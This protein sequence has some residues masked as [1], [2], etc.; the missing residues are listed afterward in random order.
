MTKIEFF[1]KEEDRALKAAADLERDFGQGIAAIESLFTVD[2]NARQIILTT[3][4]L[5]SAEANYAAIVTA[6]NSFFKPDR[7]EDAEAL[8]EELKTLRD[9]D[10]RGFGVYRANV[11]RLWRQ[12]DAIQLPPLP[13]EMRL[14]LRDGV[15][16]P[17]LSEVKKDYLRSSGQAVPGPITWET[18]LD[19]CLETVNCDSSWDVLSKPLA[20]RN[21]VVHQSAPPT[22]DLKCPRC[23]RPG[24][25]GKDCHATVCSRCKEQLP[26]GYHK[27]SKVTAASNF[28]KSS[29]D[30]NLKSNKAMKSAQSSTTSAG[31]TVTL[32][33]HESMT[34]FY[35]AASDAEVREARKSVAAYLSTIKA[36][37]KKR[38][39]S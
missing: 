29:R 20:A 24:H 27:C 14:I 31:T 33:T 13:R 17:N 23:G 5:P 12:M 21:A 22:A 28:R 8:R 34:A 6:L 16:N 18:F 37:A 3:K 36:E 9:T 26:P 35:A 19:T 1:R 30:S 10:G 25:R 39:I 2:S 15:N 32:P 4:T 11:L 38:K 7:A